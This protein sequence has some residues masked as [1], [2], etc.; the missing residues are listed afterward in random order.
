MLSFCRRWV[1]G[2]CALAV[3]SIAGRVGEARQST[4]SSGAATLATA[5]ANDNRTPAGVLKDGVLT[6]HLV[7]TT[8]RWQP[9]GQGPTDPVRVVQAFAEEGKPPQIPGPLVRVTEGTEI[10]MTVRNALPATLRLFGAT[11]R[12]CDP[13]SFVEIPQGASKEVRF[14]AG[15]AGTYFYAGTTN[16]APLLSFHFGNVDGLLSGAFVVDPKSGREDPNDR[17]FMLGIFLGEVSPQ[18]LP[19]SLAINGRSWPYTERQILPFGQPAT[20]R[21]INATFDLHPMHLHGTFY[22]VESLGTWARDTTYDH[23]SR[24]LVTTEA[25]DPGATMKMR[26]VPD[27]V[28]NW[29]FHCHIQGH[30]TGDMR[31]FDMTPAEREM[32]AH[33]GHGPHDIEHSMAG[34]VLGVTVQP[35][36]ETAA[37][38]LQKHTPRG[39][40]INIETLPNRYGADP[41]FGF[42]V[43]DPLAPPPAPPSPGELPLPPNPSPTLVLEKGEPV[44][45][46]LVNK[47]DRETSI[48]WHGIELESRNDGVAGWSGDSRQTTKSIAPGESLYVWFTPPREGT[49]MYHTHAHDRSQLSSGMY[50]ALLV[51]PDRHAFNADVEKVVLL[52]GSGPRSAEFNEAPL[53]VNR[54]LNPDPMTLKAGTKYRFR[55]VDISPNDTGI[56]SLR[57]DS[58]LVQWKAVSKDGAA[59]PPIQSTVRP[60]LQ[61][62]SVGET[63]DFEFAPSKPE[64]LRLEVRKLDAD[65]LTTM[66]VHVTN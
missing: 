44:A 41:G 32:M 35:G 11:T 7:A 53:E 2:A 33:G 13:A 46:T 34:L 31:A 66:L 60:A 61:Q 59:L 30:V 65:V 48:H 1:A 43:I 39:L 47:T 25:L 24:R 40:T 52:G 51:V 5:V 20:W 38:D 23:D 50:A 21:V 63:Y 12:P 49:F 56:V 27:R 18:G 26:W 6:L 22:T 42:T 15:K 10:R 14:A 4:T 58:G 19:A 64:D 45:I 37:P 36:D 16:T 62:I 9:E 54:S 55:L 8:V 57:G 29:L 17:I 28:G 3:L